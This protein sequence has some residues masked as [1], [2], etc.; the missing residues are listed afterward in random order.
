MHTLQRLCGLRVRLYA[1]A[2]LLNMALA[3]CHT[4]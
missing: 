4:K 2:P 1:L 3:A